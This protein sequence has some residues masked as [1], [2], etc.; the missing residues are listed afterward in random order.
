[1]VLWDSDSGDGSVVGLTMMGRAFHYPRRFQRWGE[2]TLWELESD[3]VD[4][5]RRV[6]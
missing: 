1:M 2:K 4:F 6:L 3:G 5:R